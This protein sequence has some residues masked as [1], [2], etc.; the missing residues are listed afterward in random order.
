[1]DLTRGVLYILLPIAVVF[2]IV[3]VSQG[4]PQTFEGPVTV[5][6]LEGAQQ[7]IARG[8]VA[9]QE[10]IKQLGT[11]GGGFFNANSAHPFE[12]PTAFTNFLAMLAMFA[13]PFALTYTFGRYAKDQRQGWVIFGAMAAVFL[14]GAV[15]AMRAELGGNPLFPAGVDQAL[16]N[17]EGK[18][19]KFGAGIGALVGGHHDEHE[20]RRHQRLA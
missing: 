10:V 9:T 4:V 3:L 11:N 20:H 13:I 8:P 7:T 14:I 2:A 19:L 15:I 16:G 12:N 5:T 6:T 17:M 18:E 1:M